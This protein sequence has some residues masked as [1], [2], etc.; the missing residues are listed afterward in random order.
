MP[1][2]VFGSIPNVPIKERLGKLPKT[3][4]NSGTSASPSGVTRSISDADSVCETCGEDN[5]HVIRPEPRGI[6]PLA[7]AWLGRSHPSLRL[8]GA[9]SEARL[10][11]IQVYRQHQP[12]ER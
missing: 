12:Y 2:G 9:P 1:Q 3:R 4:S 7:L 10:E 6:F 8:G 5:D 11:P